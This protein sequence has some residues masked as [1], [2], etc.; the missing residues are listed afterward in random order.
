MPNRFEELIKCKNDFVYFSQNYIKINHPKKGLIPLELYPFQKRLVETYENKRFVIGVKFR[1]GG[2]T[3]TTILYALWRC[4]F[5]ENQKIFIGS[6]TENEAIHLS[7]LISLTMQNFPEWLIPKMTQN[8]RNLKEFQITDSRMYFRNIE[9]CRGLDLTH[10]IIDEAAFIPD[11][12]AKWQVVWPSVASGGKVFV[13]STTNKVGNWFHNTYQKAIDGKND[14]H[15]FHTNYK[16]HPDYQNE[17]WTQEMR[18]SLGEKGFKQEILGDFVPSNESP[19]K[20]LVQNMTNEQ[21]SLDLLKISTNDLEEQCVLAEA[22]KRLN[23][24]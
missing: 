5:Y 17:K 14:F 4:M 1:Q 3:T 6:R 10:L 20:S 23:T 12:E 2:F 21:L 9:S 11:M 24:K 13:L 16:E 19:L 8:T 15:V 7:K 18:N 22:I